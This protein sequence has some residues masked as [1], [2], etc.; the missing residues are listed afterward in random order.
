MM[1]TLT[2]KNIA[3]AWTALILVAVGVALPPPAL[4]AYVL[5]G[6][7]LL[8]LMAEKRTVPQTLEVQQAVSQLPDGDAPRQAASLRETLYFG[9][10]DRFRSDTLGENYRRLSIRTPQDTLVVVNGQI[11]SGVPERFEIY[12]DLL[13]INSREALGTFLG[14]LGV[15]L[16]QTRLDRFAEHYCVVVGARDPLAN[17]PQLWVQ[18]D[19]FLPLRLTLPP[20]LLNPQ[21]GALEVRY[22]DWGQIEGAVYPM[23]IQIYRK[24]Q[25]FR[26][27]RVENLRADLPLDPLLFDAAALRATL[28]QWIPEPIDTSP[29]LPMEAPGVG[30][31]ADR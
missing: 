26:E 1:R 27:M 9:F 12:K 24:H 20:S 3:L 23:L 2:V 17:T 18:K 8:A 25:L 4:K 7:H 22:L 19:S 14:Q 30:W 5:S 10:P 29:A 16:D 11:R 6:R 15:D 21:E 31:P 28:P 13:M